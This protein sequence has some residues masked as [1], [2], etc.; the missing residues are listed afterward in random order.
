MEPTKICSKC[1]TEKPLFGFHK[2]AKGK[3]GLKSWCKECTNREVAVWR[4]KNP[5]RTREGYRKED[6]RRSY[7][8]TIEQYAALLL[9]QNGVCAVC[10]GPCKSN[11]RL[12]VDHIHGTNPAV[13]RGLLCGNCNRALGLFQ[14]SSR[15]CSAAAAY[16]QESNSSKTPLADV[17]K[18]ASPC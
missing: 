18:Y 7:G 3:D 10:K 6:L 13:V 14:E 16:V 12:A 8:L 15:I 9:G 5:V 1:G 17:D 2:Q 11:R 4:A